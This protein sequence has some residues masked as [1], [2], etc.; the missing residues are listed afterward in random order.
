[1][2]FWATFKLQAG[3]CSKKHGSIYRSFSYVCSVLWRDC[4]W[5]WRFEAGLLGS[6]FH[7]TGQGEIW[8]SNF[9]MQ[10]LNSLLADSF[11]VFSVFPSHKALIKSL[12]Q[13]WW[14]SHLLWAQ[15]EKEEA[16][17]LPEQE[18]DAI[19]NSS[20][21]WLEEIS[22]LAEEPTCQL[23]WNYLFAKIMEFLLQSGF[24]VAGIW[25]NVIVI[26]YTRETTPRHF[27]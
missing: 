12:K 27:Q 17:V 26:V 24:T 8:R 7:R 15:W 9:L 14:K 25:S 3:G 10:F 18:C 1:M 23:P 16:M 21:L 22:A 20:F 13:K 11:K 5:R 19:V 6:L 4:V 2:R